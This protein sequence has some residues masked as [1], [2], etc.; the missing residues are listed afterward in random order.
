[1]RVFA[2]AYV[3]ILLFSISRGA[4]AQH[5]S[6]SELTLGGVAIGQTE[7][8]IVKLHGAPSSKKNTGEG[9]LLIYPG[10][11]VYVGVGSYGVFDVISKSPK[12]CTPS[13]VC[14]GEPISKANHMYGSPVVASRETGTYF[15]YTPDGSIC[16]LQVSAP[17]GIILSLRIACHP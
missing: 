10:L 16:W 9:N 5:I 4:N 15:E 8:D 12:D 17:N 11:E 6:E 14:P 1:M 3:L 2:I 7:Q 13:K